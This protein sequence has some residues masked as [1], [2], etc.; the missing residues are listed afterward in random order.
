MKTILIDFDD[1]VCNNHFVPVINKFA[2]KE[3]VESD[4][5]IADV[6]KQIF[7][8]LKDR[9]EFNDFF[10]TVDSYENIEL[11]QG[12]FECLERLCK[13]HRVLFVSNCIH[14]ERP[15]DFM[16]QFTD[17]FA[18]I[19]KVLPFFPMENIIFSAQKD[20]FHADVII[21]DRISNLKGNISN[22][23][24]FDCF[25]N[26]KV[27]LANSNIVRIKSWREVEEFINKL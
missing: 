24:L 17:K 15:L 14:Y 25:H 11:K 23:L 12:A 21:D 16:R 27:D 3:Y 20:L 18:Y 26:Q 4:F 8:N 10:I 7:P 2:N 6:E 19:H 1:V 5:N 9:N 13:K 22:K